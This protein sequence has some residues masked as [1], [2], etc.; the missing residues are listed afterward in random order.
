[1]STV[2]NY[3]NKKLLVIIYLL[4]IQSVLILAESIESLHLNFC[5][6]KNV[7]TMLISVLMIALKNLPSLF[8]K[9]RKSMHENAIKIDSSSHTKVDK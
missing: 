6:N 4:S 8:L 5:I 7:L 3:H 2:D 9:T 1:M